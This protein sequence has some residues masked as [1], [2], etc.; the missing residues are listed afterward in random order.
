MSSKFLRDL[1]DAQ[2]PIFSLSLGQL[3]KASGSHGVDAKLIGDITRMSHE[4]MRTLRLDPQNTSGRELY[5]ALLGRVA[6]D[7][8]RLAGIIGANDSEDVRQMVPYMVAA[9]DKVTFNRTVFVIKHDKAKEFLRQMSPQKLMAKL[10]YTNV[11]SMLEGEDF[12]EVYTALRFS[13]GPEWLNQYDELFK[14]V[15]PGD[16][17]ERDLR[18]VAMDHDK[19][20]D[21]AEHFV[22]KKLHNITHTKELGVIVVVP[23]HAERMKGL[24]LKSLPLLLHYMNEVKLYSTFFKLKSRRVKN[25][26]EVVMETLIADTGTGAQMAGQYVHWRVIQRYLGRH[27]EDAPKEAFEPHVQ[28]EDLHWRRAEELLYQIDPELVFW[29]DRDYVGVNYD[30]FPVALNLFDVSFAYSNGEPYENRYAYHMR[31][32]LWNEIFARYMGMGNL[33][34][35]ILSQLDND[36]IAPEKLSA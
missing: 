24:A 13:E 3:E 21:L 1:L 14:S 16:Y 27:K 12:D 4:N 5:Q 35:Q 15:T 6:D 9:A 28:P 26:G 8:H 36:M 30:N 18:I 11:D 19:Y 20:V 10:G 2:E 17:E 23:M 31:E 29:K 7:N 34:H 33:E 25:F 22:Q 32:S